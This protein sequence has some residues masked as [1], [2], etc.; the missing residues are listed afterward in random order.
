MH[1]LILHDTLSR[2]LQIGRPINCTLNTDRGEG[3]R[4]RRSPEKRRV[5]DGSSPCPSFL[6]GPGHGL[7]FAFSPSVE[8]QS[9]D[10][11]SLDRTKKTI[12]LVEQDYPEL[13]RM[14]ASWSLQLSELCRDL[15][16]LASFVMK[17]AF[18]VLAAWG[19]H[20]KR[21]FLFC[22]GSG[23]LN[24]FSGII[25]FSSV[26]LQPSNSSDSCP[27]SIKSLP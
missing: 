23:F 17:P 19:P 9:L 7:P 1:L 16:T 27:F 5:F 8:G 12:R 24:S 25:C 4:E 20:V 10:R 18:H 2:F 26:F 15:Q 3:A 11:G 6:T 14:V 22:L 13:G 21:Q